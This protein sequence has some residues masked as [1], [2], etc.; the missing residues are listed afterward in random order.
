MSKWTP[1]RL[2]RWRSAN[3]GLGVLY[4]PRLS[5]GVQKFTGQFGP[6]AFVLHREREG[7]LDDLREDLQALGL[8]LMRAANQGRMQKP[9]QST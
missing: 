9:P 1:W 8:T 2:S 5:S 6:W 3:F 4:E 7:R